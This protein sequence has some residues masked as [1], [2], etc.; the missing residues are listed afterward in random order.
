MPSTGTHRFTLRL[1]DAP[2]LSEMPIVPLFRGS[3]VVLGDNEIANALVSRLQ[4]LGVRCDRLRAA[5]ME[6]LDRTLDQRWRE[7]AP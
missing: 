4:Q 3:A 5:T 2:R 1:R 7:E 6:D